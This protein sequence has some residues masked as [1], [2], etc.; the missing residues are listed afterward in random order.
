MERLLGTGGTGAKKSGDTM[1]YLVKKYPLENLFRIGYGAVLSMRWEAEKW[2]D[3]SWFKNTGFP[4]TF[5]GE[6]WTGVLGGVLL[7]K[8]LYFD[9]YTTGVLYREFRTLDEVEQTREAVQQ[10]MAFD[11]LLASVQPEVDPETK[12]MLDYKNLVL[13]G[14]VRYYSGLPEIVSRVEREDFQSFYRAL[15]TEKEK[16]P[17]IRKE[18]KQSFLNWLTEKSGWNVAEISA[19]LGPVFDD[20]FA[21]TETELGNVSEKN[22]DP[23]FINLFLIR[24]STQA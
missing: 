3:K 9:N 17:R 15:W 1:A 4:M 23:R 21:E 20:L 16:E 13:T 24:S 18:M 2:L 6:K 8:P 22:L 14:W 5:W 11:R 10:I 12:G 19:Q 7:K